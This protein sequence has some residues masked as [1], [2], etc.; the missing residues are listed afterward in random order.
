M[1]EAGLVYIHS[2]QTSR[3]FVGCGALVEGPFVV[4]CR[5]VWDQA[6]QAAG[7]GPVLVCFPPPQG[8]GVAVFNTAVLV[9]ACN[10][11]PN[12]PDL[13]IL[14]V[15]DPPSNSAV[16]SVARAG[17]AEIGRATILAGLAG[18]NPHDRYA[19]RLTV[20]HGSIQPVVDSEGLRQFT[21]TDASVYWS[22]HGCSGSPVGLRQGTTLAGILCLSETAARPGGNAI[23]EA[24]VLPASTIHRFLCAHVGHRSAEA[25]DIDHAKMPRI[26]DKLGASTLSVDELRSRLG[27]F[28][29]S[30]EALAAE[31]KAAPH[32]T[33]VTSSAAHSMDGAARV[34]AAFSR[35]RELSAIF[36]PVAAMAVLDEALA[37]EARIRRQRMLPLLSEKVLQQRLVHNHQGAAATLTEITTLDPDTPW[38][39]IQLGDACRQLG[40]SE[41]ALD[42][43][44]VGLRTAERDADQTYLAAFQQ[45]IGDF[46]VKSGERAQALAA[47]RACLDIARRQL[48]GDPDNAARRHEFA[49]SHN[50]IGA[51]L[52]IEG[53]RTGALAAYRVSLD[54]L[55]VLVRDEPGQLP[56][57]RDLALTHQEI[58]DMVLSRGSRSDTL[59]AHHAY[60]A[61]LAIRKRL[62]DRDTLDAGCQQD[63]AIA[64][65][66]ISDLLRR[67]GRLPEALAEA[68]VSLAI[69]QRLAEQD[70]DRAE[71]QRELSAN[72]NDV[73]YLLTR[74]T[75]RADPVGASE[76]ALEEFNAGLRIIQHLCARDPEQTGWQHDLSTSHERIGDV[77]L[78]RG[79]FPAALAAFQ[80]SLAIRRTLSTRDPGNV[81]W[82]RELCVIHNKVG[83]AFGGQA[84]LGEDADDGPTRQQSADAAFES[85]RAALAIMQ[86]LAARDPDNM[87]W[88]HDLSG[89]HERMGGILLLY[90]DVAGA[91]GEFQANLSITERLVARDPGNA[92]RQRDMIISCVKMASVDPAGPRAWISRAL[93]IAA[94]L[95]EGDRLAPADAWMIPDLQRRLQD[96]PPE[97]VPT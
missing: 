2:S 80:A 91:M 54:I 83:N 38:G 96:L 76:E 82:Q 48:D 28:F 37:E 75:H 70:P 1:I 43:Y 85:F 79:D 57:Q 90:G 16:L 41:A 68:R 63:L 30:V 66:R 49:V 92:G 7:S 35:S 17:V 12:P 52:C 81:E 73:G 77:L 45:R 6:S 78:A 39:W 95:A 61:S 31:L 69:A 22:D 53:D 44:R 47:Y 55:E 74:L 10:V 50:R 40:S 56:W 9:D 59:A 67:D 93:S 84:R 72:H 14:D 3:G 33:A 88:Q 13:V 11:D 58:G 97:A 27:F 18:R 29:D 86:P 60:S 64:H 65:G 89:I 4:T 32:P 34:L 19:P 42:A 51:V 87:V 21:G 62:A 20:I 46:L 23:H 8:N 24:F 71:F 15:G 94:R 36:E 26:L 25:R 5:H